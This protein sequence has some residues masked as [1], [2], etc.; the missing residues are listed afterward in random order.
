MDAV[1]LP[2]IGDPTEV[3]YSWPPPWAR[4]NQPTRRQRNMITPQPPVREVGAGPGR[5]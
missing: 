4:N 1:E 3:R 5:F 2:V